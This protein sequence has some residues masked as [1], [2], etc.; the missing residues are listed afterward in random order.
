MIKVSYIQSQ[1]FLICN[2]IYGRFSNILEYTSVNDPFKFNGEW[3]L[4]YLPPLTLFIPF[5]YPFRTFIALRSTST[6]WLM[7]SALQN[8]TFCHLASLLKT[9]TV[10]CNRNVLIKSI[11]LCTGPILQIFKCKPTENFVW[12]LTCVI[13]TTLKERKLKQYICLSGCLMLW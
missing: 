7:V 13:T 3:F 1:I 2:K 9:W 5:L 12:Y 8:R 11:L 10:M 6:C 4:S